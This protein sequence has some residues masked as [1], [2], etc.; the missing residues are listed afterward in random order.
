MYMRYDTKYSKKASQTKEL[1]LLYKG[2]EIIKLS[3]K[4]PASNRHTKS[5]DWFFLIVPHV[6]P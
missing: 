5:T 4:I 3:N 1:A 2:C 6:A